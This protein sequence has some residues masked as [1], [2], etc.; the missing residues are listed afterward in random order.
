MVD[1]LKELGVNL[2]VSIWPTVDQRTDNYKKMS[3]CG[4]LM[5]MDR[6]MPIHGTWMG[7]CTYYDAINPGARKFVWDCAKKNYYD[8]GIKLF[9][10]DEAEPEINAYD[11]DNYRYFDG[12]ALLCANEYPKCYIQGLSLIHISPCFSEPTQRY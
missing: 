7:P 9:W 11:A 12:P 3:E 8:L 6:G 1:E 10:L 4:Y 2:M 5:H